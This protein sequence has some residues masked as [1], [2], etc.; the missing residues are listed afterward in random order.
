MT[1]L[2]MMVSTAIL[3]LL[4][5]AVFF[6]YQMGASAWQKGITQSDLQQSAQVAKAQLAREL[7]RSTYDSLSVDPQGISFLSPMDANGRFQVDPVA[8]KPHW[9]KY[10]IFYHDPATRS[11]MW[12]EESVLGSPQ[13]LT[14]G[15]IET[16]GAAQP[17]SSY[18]NSGRAL[19]REIDSCTFA[20]TPD[21]VVSFL[22]SGQKKRYGSE[23]PEKLTIRSAVGFRN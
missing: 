16:W 18:F 17:L 20:V 22:W 12:R 11:L 13:E 15:P 1:I 3:G 6:I 2:E 21:K 19:A 4:F 9:Q 14:P 5:T 10:V 8:L 23:T 7:E